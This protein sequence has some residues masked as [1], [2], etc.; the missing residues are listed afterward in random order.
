[1]IQPDAISGEHHVPRRVCRRQRAGVVPIEQGDVGG[2][3]GRRQGQARHRGAQIVQRVGEVGEEHMAGAE[4]GGGAARQT[5]A[6]AQFEYLGDA[7]KGM[8]ISWYIIPSPHAN[9]SQVKSND[10]PAF[11]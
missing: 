5:R 8:S 10:A 9:M 1:M 3:Q 7:E 6:S 2:A 4:G 11:L